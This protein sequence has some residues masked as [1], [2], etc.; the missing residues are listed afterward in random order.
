MAPAAAYLTDKYTNR[1]IFGV[2]RGRCTEVR[3]P[4]SRFECMRDHSQ[5]YRY[6]RSVSVVQCKECGEYWKATADYTVS[7]GETGVSTTLSSKS[8][9]HCLPQEGCWLHHSPSR[10]LLPKR[11]PCL[12]C[13]CESTQTMISPS[14]TA[15][16]ADARRMLMSSLSPSNS[17]RQVNIAST[18]R[19]TNPVG[20]LRGGDGMMQN[21][22]VRSSLESSVQQLHISF[23]SLA[24]SAC[25][26]TLTTGSTVRPP[27]AQAMMRL[28]WGT[29]REPWAT[30]AARCRRSPAT[31]CCSATGRPATLP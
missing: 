31:Q 26:N 8:W 14:S 18:L 25:P 16:A 23:S 5:G 21:L 19:M 27:P 15:T 13:R 4:L 3:S 24:H 7:V 29:S 11:K 9:L 6:E 12:L 28:H 20:T 2:V 30:T 22:D 10:Y 1:D 17:R